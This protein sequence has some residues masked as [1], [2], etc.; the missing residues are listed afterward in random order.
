MATTTQI[1]E[2][3]A[4]SI[5]SLMRRFDRARAHRCTV[6]SAIER[7]TTQKFGNMTKNGGQPIRLVAITASTVDRTR[8]LAQLWYPKRESYL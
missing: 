3:N 6:A 4:I 5:R 7:A 1:E 8:D 2:T